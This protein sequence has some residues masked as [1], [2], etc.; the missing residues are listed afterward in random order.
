MDLQLDPNVS[1]LCHSPPNYDSPRSTAVLVQA[2]P[3]CEVLSLSPLYTYGES[4]RGI[5]MV[6]H[7]ISPETES[8]RL[9]LKRDRLQ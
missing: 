9:C 5:S 3:D 4:I 2:E 7:W 6:A 8:I 1:V